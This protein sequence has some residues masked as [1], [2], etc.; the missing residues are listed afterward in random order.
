[1]Y[2]PRWGIKQDLAERYAK[3]G[4]VTSAAEIFE[5][6][7]LWDEVVECYKAAGKKNKAEEIIRKQ[8]AIKET[9]RMWAALGDITDD[10]SFYEKSWEISGQKYARAKAA[11]GRL[12]FDKGDLRACYDHMQDSLKIKPLVSSA[13]FLLGTCSM[14]LSEWETALAAFSH[15]VQQI[16]DE[17]DAWANLAAIHIHNKAPSQAYPALNESIKYQRNNWRVWINKM[18][19]C[20][21]LG[22]FDEAM[23]CCHQMIDFKKTATSKDLIG[24]EPV[25]EKVVRGLVGG[26]L[27]QLLEAEKLFEGVT[28]DATGAATLDS[29]RRSVKRLG[30]LISRV[31]GVVKG[32]A[33]VWEVYLKYG[34]AV[35]KGDDFEIDCLA[36][37][38]RIVT[39][40]VKW[41]GHGGAEE[42]SVPKKEVEEKV[43]SLTTA[44]VDKYRSTGEKD[45]GKR[46]V[47]METKIKYLLQGVEGKFNLEY[48]FKGAKEKEWWTKSL[49][50]LKL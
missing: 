15:V 42:K 43:M 49:G 23:Q 3:I 8:L 50:E 36:K 2:P 28:D 9:P 22:K 45:E 19:V 27:G 11:L 16:P 31:T 44:L 13:W 37:S 12:S 18:F 34:E 1:V 24:M 25:S 46:K 32:E 5:E 39:N 40:M 21:D 17:G 48:E 10:A 29:K 41:D 35:G 20:M 14:R 38:H 6:L 4:V 7:H 26:V 47:E 30:E 33:W